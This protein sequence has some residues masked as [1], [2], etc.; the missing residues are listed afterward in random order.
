MIGFVDLFAWFALVCWFI[1]TTVYRFVSLAF[2]LVWNAYKIASF[3]PIWVCEFDCCGGAQFGDLW[4]VVLC[5]LRVLVGCCIMLVWVFVY[6]VDLSGRLLIV[7]EWL[8]L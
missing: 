2:P 3:M 4:Y 1:V 6:R 5:C 8:A 7:V